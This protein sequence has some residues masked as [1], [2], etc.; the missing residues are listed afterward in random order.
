MR[1]LNQ[2]KRFLNNDYSISTLKKFTMIF[3]GFTNTV[4]LNRYLGPELKGEYAVII[5]FLTLISIVFNLGIYQSFPNFKREH[6]DKSEDLINK[7]INLFIF[8]FFIY[9]IIGVLGFYLIN[10]F[11]Y[12]LALLFMPVSVIAQQ[13]GFLMLIEDIKFRSIISVL[14]A[15][16]KLVVTIAIFVFTRK[17]LLLVFLAYAVGNLGFMII[18]YLVKFKKRLR[19]IKFDFLF[20]KKVLKFGFL[21]MLSMLLVTLNYKLDIFMLKEMST[22]KDVGLYSVGVGLAEYAWIVPDIF[23]DVL[24][25]RTANNDS[26]ESIKFSL[27]V[28][29]TIIM[30]LIVFIGLFGKKF[31]GFMY[32]IDFVDA[33]RITFYLFFGVFSMVFFKIIGTLYIAKGNRKIYFYTLSISVLMNI[34]V[35]MLMI[36]KYGISGAALASVISY[37]FSG[38]IFLFN[39]TRVYNVK[40]IEVLFLTKKD[41]IN[42]KRFVIN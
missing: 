24:F 40:L 19:I 7:Y 32:G 9:L 21:P 29:T 31:I 14:G 6:S 23:K 17:D 34:F 37:T 8:Q 35:N 42:I 30:I 22:L 26:I 27:R 3:V 25:S 28:S 16:I 11:G 41:L 10:D 12:A 1:V 4:I 33:Y 15:I 2:V 18:A 36:P 20:T 39:F 5:N 13:L 38:S